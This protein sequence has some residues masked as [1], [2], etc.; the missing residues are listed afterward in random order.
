MEKVTHD[1]APPMVEDREQ[2]STP[3]TPRRAGGW[4]SVKYILANE[5]FEKLAS[6]SLMSNITLYLRTKYNMNNIAV[7]NVVQIWSGSSNMASIAGAF[8]TDTYLGRFRALLYGSIASLLGMLTITLTAGIHQFRPPACSN[9]LHCQKSQGWQLGILFGGL[10]LLSIGAGGIRPCNIAF[11]ADQFDTKTQKGRAQLESFF[12]WWYFS[13]TVALLIALTCVVYVQTN[14]SWT[15]GFAIPTVC[16]ALSMFIFLLGCHTYVYKKPQGS[17]FVDMVK[18]IVAACRKCELQPSGRSF[19]DPTRT[20]DESPLENKGLAHKDRFKCLDKAA[21][22]ANPSTELDDQGMSRNGWRLCSLQQVQNFKCLLGILP[23]LVSG[24]CCFMVTSQQHTFGILQ[25]TQMDR[26]IGPHFKIPP[27][28]MNLISMLSLSIWIQVFECIYIPLS[29]KFYKKA[30]RLSMGLRIKIGILLSILC[31]LV[32]ANVEKKRRHSALR[33]NSYISPSSFTLL[34]PQ[35][36]L[37]GLTEAFA[38]VAI[39]ELF[40]MQLPESMRTVSGAVFYLSMSISDYLG[41]L[42]VNIVHKVTSENGRTPWLG[43]HDLNHVRLENYYFIIAALG[44]LNL[45]YFSFFAVCFSTSPLGTELKEVQ[46]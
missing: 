21:I 38:A 10:G 4:R 26:S 6:M 25:V 12:N 15:I 39:M 29:K 35:Y 22:I 2:N 7:V 18:V 37:S 45:V 34:L 30:V 9:P 16:L 3:A 44:A 14:I 28:W 23:F 13:F 32:A 46:L 8:I 20:L 33:Q 40:T 36:A 5:S 11:G 27:G 19:Y 24:T 31:M 42:V 17:I 1:P 43:H 41:S